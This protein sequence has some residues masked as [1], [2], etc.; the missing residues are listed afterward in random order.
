MSVFAERRHEDLKKANELAARSRGTLQIVAALGNPPSN[1]SIEFKLKTAG[2]DRYPFE[3]QEYF[4][5]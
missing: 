4:K 1:L 2:S 5:S 3:V